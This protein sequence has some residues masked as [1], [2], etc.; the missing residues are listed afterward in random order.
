MFQGNQHKITYIS[1][2][3]MCAFAS[4][5]ESI[6]KPFSLQ[7]SSPQSNA[8]VWG[9]TLINL[10]VSGRN[11]EKIILFL[12]DSSI[13]Q[14]TQP[15]Y[16]YELNTKN[17]KDGEYILTA[18]LS[19]QQNKTQV[20]I[21]IRNNLLVV[22]ADKEQLSQGTRCFIFLSD[23]EGK[24]FVS[25]EI[26]NGE[27]INIKK[28][29]FAFANFTLNEAYVTG[30]RTI[31]IYSFQEVP[32]GEWSLLKNNNYPVTINTVSF[33]FTE[34]SNDYYFMSTSGDDG[35]L[36]DRNSI[37][38]G[39][40]RA[41]TKLFIREF[42]K[43]INNFKILDNINPI[44]RKTISLSDVIIPLTIENTTLKG[45]SN[46][47][48]NVRLFGFTG[49]GTLE[50]YNLGTFFSKNGE[51]K[52][53]YPGNSFSNYGSFSFFKDDNITINSF[54]RTKKSDL[55]PLTAEVDFKSS[56]SQSASVATFGT[57]DI[58][59]VTWTYVNHIQ[60]ISAYWSLIGPSGRGQTVKLPDLPQEVRTASLNVNIADLQFSNSLQVSDFDIA[61][62][63][64]G[65]IKFI[66][67]NS[68][69]G[70]YAFGLSWKEQVFTKSGSTSGRI[71]NQQVPTLS[72]K[73]FK[74]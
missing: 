70:P 7:I 21:S 14:L 69:S 4:C 67:K 62:D 36:Y 8:V 6:D 40:N 26:R 71:S 56:G 65:Y 31:A 2:I 32:R 27:K 25:T 51:V 13:A 54:Q 38:L 23:Q 10:L 60:G 22:N 24:T 43:S 55:Y 49:N 3:L 5:K 61:T 45:G 1:L 18:K 17:I 30:T 39:I 46:K 72:D 57:H 68:L 53:E 16:T 29:D 12:G 20:N 11:E 37:D 66:S 58:Y 52:I 59:A 50:F 19:N 47:R 48:G 15:P 64:A 35:F 74:K 9:T 42:G 44:G 41:P 28:E 73:F 33:D 63:Y 34:I